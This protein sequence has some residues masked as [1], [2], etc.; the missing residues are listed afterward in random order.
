MMDYHCLETVKVLKS[1]I[2]R[3]IEGKWWL[4]KEYQPKEYQV[5]EIE[6]AMS[7]ILQIFDNQWVEDVFNEWLRDQRR[8]HLMIGYLI[9]KGSYPLSI[10]VGSCPNF[11]EKYI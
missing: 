6:R 11:A 9:A 2:K 7:K 8:H 5:T 10:L 3:N 1:G 4:K